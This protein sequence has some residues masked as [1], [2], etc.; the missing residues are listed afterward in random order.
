MSG[1]PVTFAPTTRWPS[2]SVSVRIVPRPRS[3]KELRPCVPLDV[4]LVPVVTP[5]E[6]CSDGS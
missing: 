3:E 5:V 1:T 4:L 2:S 6:P